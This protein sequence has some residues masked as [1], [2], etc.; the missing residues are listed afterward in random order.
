MHRR[1]AVH[2]P[3]PVNIG[4]VITAWYCDAVP[5]VVVLLYHNDRSRYGE[6][7]GTGCQH[8]SRLVWSS[9]STL[10]PLGL[11]CGPYE[12]VAVTGGV[13]NAGRPGLAPTCLNVGASGAALRCCADTVCNRPSNNLR[14]VAAKLPDIS[15]FITMLEQ[16]MDFIVTPGPF[17][18]PFVRHQ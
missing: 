12:K 18:M 3:T 11:N 14:D 5:L 2:V 10:A 8:D 16:H 7:S 13:Y 4:I 15:A 6:S 1:R 9:S 17:T